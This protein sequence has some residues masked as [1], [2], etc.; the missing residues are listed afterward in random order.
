MQ[1]TTE[2]PHNVAIAFSGG[3]DSHFAYNFCKFGRRNIR[4]IH[5]NHGTYMANTYEYH[6]RVFA[7]SEDIDLEVF[8]VSGN[9]ENDWRKERYAIFQDY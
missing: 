2:I 8:R 9:N 4:L 1:L 7:D 3:V 5:I 6:V